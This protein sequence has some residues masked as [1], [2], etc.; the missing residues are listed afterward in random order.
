MRRALII[1]NLTTLAVFRTLITFKEEGCCHS[2]PLFTEK[3]PTFIL[4][5]IETILKQFHVALPHPITPP[6]LP[7]LNFLDNDVP[8]F[9]LKNFLNLQLKITRKNN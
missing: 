3:A 7:F 2:E 4:F 8:N 9:K 5:Q 1:L 6:S